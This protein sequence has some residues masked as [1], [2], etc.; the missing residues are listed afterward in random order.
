M[1]LP[2][3]LFGQVQKSLIVGMHQKVLY[4]HITEQMVRHIENSKNGDL[5]LR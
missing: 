5:A 4:S 3:V 1:L 2:L